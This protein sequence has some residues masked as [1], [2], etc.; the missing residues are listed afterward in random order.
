MAKTSAK[1]AKTKAEKLLSIPVDKRNHQGL[2][3]N[4]IERRKMKSQARVNPNDY[5]E[6]EKLQA[7]WTENQLGT[8]THGA[9]YRAGLEAYQIRSQSLKL[10]RGVTSTPK[11]SPTR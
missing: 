4:Q 8:L 10:K 2:Y 9:I 11:L 6:A 7:F 1:R 3:S 5:K